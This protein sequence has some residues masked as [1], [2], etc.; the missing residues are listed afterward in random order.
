MKNNKVEQYI[1]NLTK[2]KSEVKALR[3][4]LIN[5]GLEESFKWAKPCYCHNDNNI[6]IIQAF[7]SSLRLMFFKG[8][9]LKDPKK[10]L[11]SNGPNS[12]SA[13]RLE[14]NSKS[15]IN[16]N[17]T[18]IKNFIKQAIL[19]EDSGTK[20]KFKKSPEPIPKELKDE[21]S[22]KPK[23]K[24]AFENLTPG[25]QRA[26]ILYFSSAKQSATRISRI[27]KYSPKILKGLGFND[28]E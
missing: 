25:R 2:W 22:K 3:E 28:L 12:Q 18:A 13:M 4:L 1:K 5:A 10:L 26:Y 21:F 27:Q 8:V 16:T 6:A 23:L 7:S 24:K 11:V 14:F 19:L 15:E 20:V 17:S 9:L